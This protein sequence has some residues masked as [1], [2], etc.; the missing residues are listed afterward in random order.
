MMRHKSSRVDLLGLVGWVFADLLLA[1]LVVFLGTQPG[2]PS[3]G[4]DA[5]STT[6]T[7]TTTTTAPPTTTTTTP[8]GVDKEF[9]CIRVNTDPGLL[10]GPG[11]EAKDGYLSL[12]AADLRNKLEERQLLDREAGVVLSFGSSPEGNP[13]LGKTIA[14]NY[15]ELVLSRIPQVFG[16]AATRPFWGGGVEATGSIELNLYLVTGGANEALPPGFSVEC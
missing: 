5:T 7:S 15:N 16:G 12:L 9:V 14:Q 2:D 11:G 4:A 8:P 13:D 10:N 3:A 1:L 6:S